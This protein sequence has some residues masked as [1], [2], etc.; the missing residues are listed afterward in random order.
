[1]P[2]GDDFP[3]MWVDKSTASAETP[4]RCVGWGACRE[5]GDELRPL[6]HGPVTR[7]LVLCVS[8]EVFVSG[9]TSGTVLPRRGA[10]SAGSTSFV[11]GSTGGGTT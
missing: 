6:G 11:R 5:L 8:D 3:A 1:M 7:R 4:R 10:P 2:S 9:T